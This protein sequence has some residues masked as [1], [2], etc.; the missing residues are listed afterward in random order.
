[1]AKVTIAQLEK[2]LAE[3]QLAYERT[4]AALTGAVQ[5]RDWNRS[6]ALQFEGE[7]LELKQ[8]LARELRDEITPLATTIRT[9]AETVRHRLEVSDSSVAQMASLISNSADELQERSRRMIASLNV[10]QAEV[11][12][13]V[14]ALGALLDDWRLKHS[15]CRFELLVGTGAAAIGLGASET[16]DIALRCTRE[17]I[18]GLLTGVAC[19]LI[20]VSCHVEQGQLRLQ[21]ASDEPLGVTASG[22]LS[23]RLKTIVPGGTAAVHVGKG[24]AG[25]YEV[26]CILPWPND[27]V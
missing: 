6:L 17:A 3:L 8:Q 7:L 12:G 20:L 24:E 14:A 13:L 26:V 18:D 10:D 5:E 9:L 2:N 21:I 22:H 4:Q 25:G 19:R 16:E 15:A 23:Q 27:S 11:Q 1:M